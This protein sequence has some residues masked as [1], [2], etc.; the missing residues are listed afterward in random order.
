MRNRPGRRVLVGLGVVL[1]ALIALASRAHAAPP[2]EPD[3][4]RADDALA[5]RY[6]NALTGVDDRDAADLEEDAG[7]ELDDLDLEHDERVDDDD[8]DLEDG[9]H[10]DATSA[11]ATGAE[12]GSLASLDEL[13]LPRERLA[14]SEDT[15]EA[16]L[17]RRLSVWGRLD[18]AVSLKQATTAPLH[19]PVY[20][21]EE[22]WLI[23][24]WRN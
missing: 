16:G 1:A 19:T 12:L 9:E 18:V 23:A 7:E 11:G 8:D 24:T 6:A 20:R 10:A 21:S 15:R 2:G 14:G 13:G 5:I 17:R 22:L 4:G 3:A